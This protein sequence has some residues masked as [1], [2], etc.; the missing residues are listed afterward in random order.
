MAALV[1]PTIELGRA[2]QV[3]LLRT[4]GRVV[5]HGPCGDIDRR[6]R[7][8]DSPSDLMSFLAFLWV[9]RDGCLRDFARCCGSVVGDRAQS[10]KG[11]KMTARLRRSVELLTMLSAAAL[12]GGC[13]QKPASGAGAQHV[14][15]DAPFAGHPYAGHFTLGQGTHPPSTPENRLELRRIESQASPALKARTG[16]GAGAAPV[17]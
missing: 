7:N 14:S 11:A 3:P 12:F 1:A 4:R 17:H 16:E 8:P 9:E 5:A 6:R 10:R 13:S 2:V 15:G